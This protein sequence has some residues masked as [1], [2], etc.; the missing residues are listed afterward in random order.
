MMSHL[1][2]AARNSDPLSLYLLSVSVTK[3]CV[4]ASVFAVVLIIAR[5]QSK[6]VPPLALSCHKS[7]FQLCGI[8]QALSLVTIVHL[9]LLAFGVFCCLNPLLC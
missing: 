5:N 6:V 7:E 4:S 8:V 2:G 1:I 3:I 9:K